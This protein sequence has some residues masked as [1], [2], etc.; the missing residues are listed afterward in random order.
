MQTELGKVSEVPTATLA[1]AEQAFFAEARVK[2]TI[3]ET[4]GE[5]PAFVTG[6]PEFADFFKTRYWA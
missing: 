6:S 1:V 2:P 4:A 5:N 3:S